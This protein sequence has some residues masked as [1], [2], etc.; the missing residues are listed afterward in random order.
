MTIQSSFGLQAKTIQSCGITV[1]GYDQQGFE[2]VAFL[3]AAY[4]MFEWQTWWMTERR[5]VL[6]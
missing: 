3:A 6:L 5:V 1:L 4:T 2:Q